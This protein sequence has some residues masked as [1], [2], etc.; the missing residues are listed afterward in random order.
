[1]NERHNTVDLG[2]NFNVKTKGL[3]CLMLLSA[4][5]RVSAQ[6]VIN[7]IQGGT[8]KEVLVLPASYS[9]DKSCSDIDKVRT[10]L[11]PNKKDAD[12]KTQLDKIAMDVAKKGGNVFQ[13]N[14]IED[15]KQAGHY[16]F[17]G[18]AYYTKDYDRIKAEALDKEKKKLSDGTC[19]YLTIYYPEYTQGF[20]GDIK[21][22]IT[23]ND[24]LKLELWSNTK[25]VLKITKAGSV[26]LKVNQNHFKQNMDVDV[27][28]GNDYYVRSYVNYSGAG[29]EISTGDYQVHVNGFTPYMEKIN[30]W[31]GEIESSMVTRYVVTKKI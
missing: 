15:H 1:M 13:I 2:M 14:R 25:Y 18:E 27:K 24:T 7:A 23:I 19:A 10:D 3:I 12:F 29:K 9:I 21:Y 6:W 22:Y 28:M 26:K 31:Q 11:L 17:W 20:S 30:E 8:T 5:T 4:G 16:R